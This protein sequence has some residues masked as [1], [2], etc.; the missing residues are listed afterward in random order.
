MMTEQFQNK[1]RIPSARVSWH[2]YNGGIY[3]ITI[4]TAERKYYF[5]EI[6]DDN[7]RDAVDGRD[8]EV[9]DG[10]DAARHV[11]T[12][13][14]MRLS[15]IGMCATENFN[16]VTDHYPYAEIPLFVVMPNHIHAV[17]V[18][19]D[20]KVPY[21]RNGMVETRRATSLPSETMANIAN[22]QGWLSVVIGGLKSAI[23][24]YAHD[25]GIPFAWQ[26]RF[27]D[28]IVRS[29]DE[30]NRIGEYIESNVVKWSIDK[31]NTDIK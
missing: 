29:Q 22:M 23:T 10:R 31:F 15:K 16:H 2:D 25:N 13:P 30:L 5:G 21:K 17:V 27:Y 19:D 3:F 1:Y 24:R 7:G 11:S 4:C 28:H 9:T 14:Q 20:E 26:T 8:A 18:I 6:V 12:E